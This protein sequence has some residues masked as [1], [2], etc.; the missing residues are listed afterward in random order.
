MGQNGVDIRNQGLILR[1]DKKIWIDRG[2][3]FFWLTF[4]LDFSPQATRIFKNIFHAKMCGQHFSIEPIKKKLF[5]GG[6]F[7]ELWPF[8]WKKVS[9]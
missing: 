4:D 6:F 3:Y 9:G 5:A 2:I 7:D 8:L 1:Q